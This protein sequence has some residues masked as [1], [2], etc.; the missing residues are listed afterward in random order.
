MCRRM[1]AGAPCHVVAKQV[2]SLELCECLI[3][4]VR[5]G[6]VCTGFAQP[7]VHHTALNVGD[8]SALG[9]ELQRVHQPSKMQMMSGTPATVPIALRI[10]PSTQVRYPPRGTSKEERSRPR[11]PCEVL[12]HAASEL[13]F[14]LIAVGHFGNHFGPPA[15]TRSRITR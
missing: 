3:D 15:A 12:N 2:P 11:T 6:D 5:Y 10:A 8:A 13:G 1:R 4:P 9:F 14:G 7:L